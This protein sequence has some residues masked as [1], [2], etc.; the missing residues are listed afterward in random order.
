VALLDALLPPS[1]AGCGRYGSL[2]CDACRSS[3]RS[4]SPAAVTFVQA[5][6]A[7]VI[8]EALT[9]ALAAFRHER[10]LRR[11]LGRLKYGGSP[12]LATPLATLAAPSL[13]RLVEIT[14][15][16]RLVP[17]PV[18]RDRLRQRGYNQAGLLAREL[19]RLTQ[20]GLSDCL[21][22]S[23]ATTRQHRLDRARRLQNLRGAF[24][25][26]PGARPPPVVV[27]VDDILTTAATMEACAGALRDAGSESVYGF[28]IA[29]EV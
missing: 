17:V 25:I 19:A 14:G 12:R 3:F 11:A 7:I 13:R 6:P 10:A 16:A 1:C 8:G 15:P 4:A 28:A 9:M 18:H 2:L 24:G 23:R 21:V 27:L 20:M 26:R 29:R 22:R 5:D